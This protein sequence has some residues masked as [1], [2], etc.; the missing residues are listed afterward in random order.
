MKNDREKNGSSEKQGIFQKATAFWQASKALT[1]IG[2]AISALCIV[3][4]FATGKHTLD[5]LYYTEKFLP[6]FMGVLV[7]LPLVL[8][9][10]NAF[11]IRK[12]FV[13]VIAICF[14]GATLVTVFV[15]LAYCV[16]KLTYFFMAGT[17]Y[18]IVAAFLL[19]LLFLAIYGKIDKKGK[20]I[21]FAILIPIFTVVSIFGVLNIKPSYIDADAVV[22]AVEDEYQICWGTSTSTVGYVKVGEKLYADDTAGALN[23]SDI[24]KVC[25]PREELEKEGK[26]TVFYKGILLNRAYMTSTTKEKSKTYDFRTV[27]TS[28]GLQIYNVSDNHL[29]NAGALR[30]GS[31]WGDKLDLL[32]ANGDHLNDVSSSWQVKRMYKLLSGITGSERPVLI[33]R[34]NH[35]AVGSDLASLPRYF[36]SREGTFYYTARF[37][38]TLFV[39]LDVANDMGDDKKIISA[40]ANFDAYR[41]QETEW[42]HSVAES[43]IWREEGVEHVIGVC[44]MAFPVAL[45]EY[46]KQTSELWLAETEKMGME[47]MICGHSHRIVYFEADDEKNA[48]NYPVLL[49]SIRNDNDPLH[50]SASATRFTGTAVEI[51]EKIVVR[52]TD[53]KHNVKGEHVIEKEGDR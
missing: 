11:V 7:C 45:D 15:F 5:K 10:L 12:K 24:H 36:G 30:A 52:F 44:H 35:E 49:G 26:Y 3:L 21:V 13:S 47:L 46:H 4:F 37:G 48:A 19:F 14:G 51:G 20:K 2:G 8:V 29:L 18:F 53:S 32:I 16:S 31:Y 39:V 50:E 25:V 43:E 41:A 6:Y 38:N 42:V 9:A 34:G 27:D 28:D 33:T 23:V 17:P 40:T 22:F 1:I